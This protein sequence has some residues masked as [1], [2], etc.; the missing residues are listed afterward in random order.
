MVAGPA[1]SL[2]IVAA[3]LLECQRRP[4]PQGGYWP[5]R[6]LPRTLVGVPRLGRKI[7]EKLWILWKTQDSKGSRLWITPSGR[8]L[9]HGASGRIGRALGVPTT[10]IP[11][12]EN[13]LLEG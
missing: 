9:P 6:G 1:Q 5:A 4:V 11:H 10:G 8:L 12:L 2:A 3:S 7:V 13:T